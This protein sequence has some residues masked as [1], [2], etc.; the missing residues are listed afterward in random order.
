MFPC[1]TGYDGCCLWCLKGRQTN[2]VKLLR[3]RP[4][5]RWQ[6]PSS[7]VSPAD[8]SVNP[9]GC[10]MGFQDSTQTSTRELRNVEAEK[11]RPGSGESYTLENRRGSRSSHLH[12]CSQPQN[13]Q[14]IPKCRR[15]RHST[16]LPVSESADGWRARKGE[17]PHMTRQAET[18][19]KTCTC[20]TV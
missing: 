2:R 5:L 13:V 7:P 14:R 17:F 8:G 11:R 3:A 15:L 19:Y 4:I 6:L 10:L 1:I 18:A 9:A 16:L 20:R 12:P